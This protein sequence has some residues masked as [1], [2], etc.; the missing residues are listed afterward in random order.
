[1]FEWRVAITDSAITS[2]E[3]LN[4]IIAHGAIY[5]DR[6]RRFATTKK[7][8]LRFLSVIVVIAKS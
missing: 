1:M 2:P 6:L 8:R 5:G 7:A 3:S 4:Q